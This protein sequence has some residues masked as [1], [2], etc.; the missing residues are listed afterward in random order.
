MGQMLRKIR[1]NSQGTGISKDM[2]EKMYLAYSDVLNFEMENGTI[3]PG[4]QFVHK[5]F[6]ERIAEFNGKISVCDFDWGEPVGGEFL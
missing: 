3:V 6:E 5:T 2:P 1:E 4:K